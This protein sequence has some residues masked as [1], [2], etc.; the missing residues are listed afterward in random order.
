MTHGKLDKKWPN[1]NVY[2][3]TNEQKYY[4]TFCSKIT[5][6]NRKKLYIISRIAQ[7]KIIY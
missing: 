7:G 4:A 6:N 1:M 5:E 2:K 3:E